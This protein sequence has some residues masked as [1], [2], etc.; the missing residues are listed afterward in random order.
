MTQISHTSKTMNISL[1]N[2]IQIFTIF[3]YTFSLNF[4][5]QTDSFED[6]SCKTTKWAHPQQSLKANYWLLRFNFCKRRISKRYIFNAYLS[7]M[8]SNGHFSSL[9]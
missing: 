6:C 4:T 9:T 8:H 7:T 2:K 1:V 5:T 3:T